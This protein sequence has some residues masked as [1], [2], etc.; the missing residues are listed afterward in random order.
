MNMN[1]A[2]VLDNLVRI[3]AVSAVDVERRMARVVFHDKQDPNG[4]PLVSGWMRVSQNLPL[5]VIKS[6]DEDRSIPGEGPDEIKEIIIDEGVNPRFESI[7]HSVHRNLGL[8]EKYAKGDEVE[9]RL[10]EVEPGV[11]NKQKICMTSEP[12]YIK[13][14]EGDKMLIKIYPWLPY[15][16]Q[17]VICLYLPSG[18]SDGFVI[19]GL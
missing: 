14:M 11:K 7:Y 10:Y 15:I 9:E 13:E 17:I 18:G 3:G 2:A 4:N 5:I 6:W 16:D 19:G 8:N 1:P 12:D